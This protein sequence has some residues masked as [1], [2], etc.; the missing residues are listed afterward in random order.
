MRTLQITNAYFLHTVPAIKKCH[1]C[2]SKKMKVTR[3][4]NINEEKGAIL[5][6][7]CPSTTCKKCGQVH[8]GVHAMI[9]EDVLETWFEEGNK[10]NETIH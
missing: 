3:I 5:M 9:M 4:T 1:R 7:N 6:Q 8:I 2:K 10:T